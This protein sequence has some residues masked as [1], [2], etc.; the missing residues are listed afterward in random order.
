[1]GLLAAILLAIWLLGIIVTAASVAF[2]LK[3]EENG[4]NVLPADVRAAMDT[5]PVI[6]SI[7][8]TVFVV[9]WPATLVYKLATRKN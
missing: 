3:A 9:F 1:M 7:T 2:T 5:Y 8:L 6:F 4:D